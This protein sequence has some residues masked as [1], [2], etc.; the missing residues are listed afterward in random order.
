VPRQVEA[1]ARCAGCEVSPRPRSLPHRR[2]F[3]VHLASLV[4]AVPARRR[5]AVGGV[6]DGSAI[7][8]WT[9]DTTSESRTCLER[10]AA[11]FEGFGGLSTEA[12]ALGGG[13]YAIDWSLTPVPGYPCRHRVRLKNDSGRSDLVLALFVGA[14]ERIYDTTHAWDLAPGRYQSM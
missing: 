5:A 3:G 12:F 14:D 11:R 9:A 7:A 4:P 6:P 1:Q 13:R 10:V 2:P 8:I